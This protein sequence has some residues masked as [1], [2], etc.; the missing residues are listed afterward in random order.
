MKQRY[1]EIV[2]KDIKI[3]VEE[4]I[5]IVVSQ[6]ENGEQILTIVQKPKRLENQP[7]FLKMT[8]NKRKKIR[9]WIKSQKGETEREKEFL[10]IVKEAL[11]TVHYDYWI[12]TM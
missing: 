5:A 3:R 2:F 11:K 10:R 8:S 6:E 12:A 9:K 4:G 7:Y 1:K